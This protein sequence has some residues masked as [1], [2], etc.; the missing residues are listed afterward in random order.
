MRFLCGKELG[1][2][3]HKS[4]IYNSLN[5]VDSGIYYRRMYYQQTKK[6]VSTLW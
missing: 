4:F 5:D 1:Q 6:K 2:T 3:V